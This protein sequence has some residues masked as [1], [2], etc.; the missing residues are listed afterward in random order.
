MIRIFHLPE[1]SQLKLESL[2][3]VEAIPCLQP[4]LEIQALAENL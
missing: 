3:E 4:L 2:A 1:Y